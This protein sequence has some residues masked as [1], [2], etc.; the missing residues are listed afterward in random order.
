MVSASTFRWHFSHFSKCGMLPTPLAVPRRLWLV[1]RAG[2][3]FAL[4]TARIV[5][6]IPRVGLA[7]D[8][9]AVRTQHRHY[10]RPQPRPFPTIA[11]T[12]HRATLPITPVPA[13][14]TLPIM[15]LIGRVV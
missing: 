5:V 7:L 9:P 12:G 2:A 8:R 1:V 15:Y 4:D 13:G 6:I 14:K 3:G 10:H 11:F